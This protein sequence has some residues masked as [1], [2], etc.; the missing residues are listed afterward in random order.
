M[1]KALAAGGLLFSPLVIIVPGAFL[2]T[3]ATRF[4][5]HKLNLHQHIWKPAWFEM[6]LFVCYVALITY[7]GK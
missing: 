1:F 6:G 3:A 4:L 5:L 2:L 7:L